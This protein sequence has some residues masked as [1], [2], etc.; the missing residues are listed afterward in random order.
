MRTNVKFVKINLKI[1]AG[2]QQIF[3]GQK[4]GN[5]QVIHLLGAALKNT[6]SEAVLHIDVK[7]AF[8]SLNCDPD[9]KKS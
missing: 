6:H 8:N 1:L 4:G 2:D 9:F 7:T 5:E 3:M